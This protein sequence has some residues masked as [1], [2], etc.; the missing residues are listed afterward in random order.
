MAPLE[1]I[2]GNLK[3]VSDDLT[4]TGKMAREQMIHAQGFMNETQQNIRSQIV[5]LRELVLDTVEEARGVVMQ[6]IRQYSAIASAIA[7]GVRTFFGR[8]EKVEAEIQTPEIVATE[9]IIE[10]KEPAA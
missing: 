6:P 1:T 8:K 3:T 5:E 10:R 4:V 9:I 2:T 7:V